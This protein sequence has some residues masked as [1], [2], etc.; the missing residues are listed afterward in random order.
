MF[1]IAGDVGTFDQRDLVREFLL[2]AVLP[3]AKDV[4][5]C[6]GNH[7]FYNNKSFTTD[8]VEQDWCKWNKEQKNV[9]VLMNSSVS[10]G[11]FLFVGGT[12]WTNVSDCL[13]PRERDKISY[14][15][16]DYNRIHGFTLDVCDKHH[17]TY[18]DTTA[19][20]ISNT[21]EPVIVVSHHLPSHECIAPKYQHC[22]VLNQAFA[23]SLVTRKILTPF[24][25]KIKLY[26]H[27]H[28]H[29][30]IN[31]NIEGVP[32]LCWPRGYNHEQNDTPF[33]PHQF[34]I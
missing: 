7:E 23:S 17:Q 2:K 21:K 30:P 1:I 14:M 33:K 4:V 29:T 34:V 16:N 8:E 27:G 15:M 24:K 3:Y 9:H 11:G 28:T 31:M 25:D 5:F 19:R 13:Q 6:L 12:A 20:I 32:I 22:G 18:L 10:L 26:I